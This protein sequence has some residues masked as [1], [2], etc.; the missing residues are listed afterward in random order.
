MNFTY[1]Y[2]GIITGGVLAL[3]V[4]TSMVLTL[5]KP[6]RIVLL[7]VVVLLLFTGTLYGTVGKM[8]TI[9]TRGLGYLPISLINIYLIVLFLIALTFITKS[10]IIGKRDPIIIHLLILV[11]LF[12]VYGLQSIIGP[13]TINNLLSDYGLFNFTNLLLFYLVLKWSINDEASLDSFE[14]VFFGACILMSLYGITRYVAFGG[15]PANYY[16][17]F[18]AKNVKITYFDY[19]QSV[20]FSIT[21][22]YLYL[23]FQYLRIFRLTE[24]AIAI[25]CVANIVLSFRRNAWLGLGLV[26]LWLLLTADFKR[27]IVMMI[28]ACLL[29]GAGMLVA[30][31]RF[32]PEFRSLKQ[33]SLLEDIID[34]KGNI[35]IES[36]RFGE[37]YSAVLVANRF[38]I[39]GL[40]PWGTN[41]EFKRQEI[42]RLGTFVHSSFVHMYIKM[43]MI[44]LALYV[45]LLLNYVFWWLRRRFTEWNNTHNKI[46]AESFFCGFLFWIPDAFLGTPIIIYRHLQILALLL[47]IPV[48]AFGVDRK[49][50]EA[51][52]R[53]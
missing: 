22:V 50:E 47:A 3:L 6:K 26:L 35:A 49:Q 4:L 52:S 18:E 42:E 17:N 16:S 27:K 21:L 10:T 28:S 11:G 2:S 9:Y 38:P 31:Q 12:W 23:R 46:I 25:V 14:K 37:L 32:T 13:L 45:L 30:H 8:S 29:F 1:E 19:G 20:L 7:Y 33:S 53:A 5:I 24:V 36:G 34:R 39:F 48:I 43:G 51:R 44:G 15:D 41:K 40:G